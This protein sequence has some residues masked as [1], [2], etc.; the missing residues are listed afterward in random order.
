MNSQIAKDGHTL[1]MKMMGEMDPEFRAEVQTKNFN[2]VWSRY[3]N[4]K[5]SLR[6]CRALMRTYWSKRKSKRR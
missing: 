6:L 4:K 3:K 1:T 5:G 2:D